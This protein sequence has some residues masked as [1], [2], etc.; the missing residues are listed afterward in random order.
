[1]KIEGRQFQK[2]S[3]VME[4]QICFQKKLEAYLGFHFSMTRYI[5]F[6]TF[7]LSV[8]DKFVIHVFCKLLLL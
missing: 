1:M 7:H 6:S 2:L 8:P 3:L 5:A 4:S